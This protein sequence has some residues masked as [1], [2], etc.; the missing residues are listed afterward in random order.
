MSK[1]EGDAVLSAAGRQIDNLPPG[2]MTTHV[3]SLV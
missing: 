2:P 1:N 3:I